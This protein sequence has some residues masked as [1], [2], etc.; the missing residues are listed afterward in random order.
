MRRPNR[1]I[2]SARDAEELVTK[3]RA[4]ASLSEDFE[5]MLGELAEAGK[6]MAESEVE[7]LVSEAVA[8]SRRKVRAART[9]RNAGER[10]CIKKIV[11]QMIFR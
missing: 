9:G 6:T 5:R 3:A 8:E 4:R 10:V 11:L 1:G 2:K 7:S